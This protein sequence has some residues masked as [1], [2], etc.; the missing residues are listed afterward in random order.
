METFDIKKYAWIAGTLALAGVFLASLAFG[1]AQLSAVKHPT[2][3]QGTITVTG[4]GEVSAV[5]DIATVSFT[6]RESA[7]T[8]AEAQVLV[9][10]KNKAAIDA[11]AR[12]GVEEKD[13]KTLYYNVTPKYE[14]VSA[15]GYATNPRIV[16]Y[17]VS[18]SVEAKVRK[19][20]VAGDVLGALGAANITEISGPTFTIDNPDELQLK[21]KEEAI[22]EAKDH[23]KDIARALGMDLGDVMQFSEDGGTVYPMYAR[24]AANQS[25]SYGKGGALGPEVTL[26]TGENTIKSHVTITYNLR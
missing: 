17:E 25:L 11:L 6:I 10:A 22:A 4:D 20:D 13:R 18:Q 23:A 7:K 1:A 8:V 12:L 5:P 21:A 24:D 16:G 14:Y 26:P 15:G 3:Q 19:T 2:G 9:E